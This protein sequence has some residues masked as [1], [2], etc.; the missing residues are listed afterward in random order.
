MNTAV[1]DYKTLYL[2]SQKQLAESMRMLL[3]APLLDAC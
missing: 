2:E 3:E 1:P